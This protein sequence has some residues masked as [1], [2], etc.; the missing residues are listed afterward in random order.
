MGDNCV[1]IHENV[2]QAMADGAVL[3]VFTKIH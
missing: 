2:R 1:T 3:M